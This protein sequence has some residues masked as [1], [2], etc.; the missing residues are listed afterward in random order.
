MKDKKE[1]NPDGRLTRFFPS[2]GLRA[3]DKPESREVSGYAIVF[4]S[5][6]EALYEDDE[7]V[8]REIISPSAVSSELL[9]SSDII[10][11]F[12]H[13]NSR[14]LGRSRSG[15]GSMSYEVD[16]HGVRFR[17]DMPHTPDGDTMLELVRRGDIAGCSFCFTTDY[18][19]KKCVAP[20][21][22]REG[23]KD[24]TTYRVN[25]I[26]GLY[27]FSL[28]VTPAYP[29]TECEARA[30]KTKDGTDDHGQWETQVSEMRESVKT[31]TNKNI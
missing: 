20:E 7:E 23:K 31:Q 5:P 17:C 16:A 14:V 8:V 21:K 15:K 28:V 13:D 25:R 19:D 12:N 10:L 27:D 4:D 29:A 1:T 18:R 2:C 6:S 30:F 3:S 22:G 11:N 26:T 24:L 9:A